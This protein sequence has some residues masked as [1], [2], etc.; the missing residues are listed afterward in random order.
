VRVLFVGDVVGK[1]GRQAVAALLP[2]I[3]REQRIDLAIVNGENA[4]GGSGLTAE[5]AR[6]LQAAGADV[7]TN[8]NHVWD[9]RA[10]IKEIDTLEFCLRPLNLPPGNPGRGWLVA[11]GALV[12]N[13]I[14]R[15]F[16]AEQDDPFRAMDALLADLGVDAPKVRILDWHAEATSEKLAMGW[17]LDGRFSAVL[18]SHTHVPTADARILPNGTALVADAGM[19]GPRDSV[20]GIDPQIIVGRYLDH[21]PRRFEVATGVVQFNSVLVDVDEGT[22]RARS[23]ERVDR[24]W[25]G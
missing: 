18:G 1:P 15:V 4:A 9:Q 17:H 19:V 24:E 20:L 7:V 6:E 13:A 12:A 10:F 3:R 23:V 16:M 25:S 21:L 11:N 14:G 5:I 8:G 2:G 22:G